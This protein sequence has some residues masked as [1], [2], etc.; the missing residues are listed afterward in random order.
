[1]VSRI[2]LNERK[3]A[4]QAGDAAASPGPGVPHSSTATE[5]AQGV[6]VGL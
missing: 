4:H 5:P 2:V 1:V 3:L 6:E